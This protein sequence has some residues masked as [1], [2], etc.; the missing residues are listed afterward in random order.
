MITQ[1]PTTCTKRAGD[2]AES[3]GGEIRP[4]YIGPAPIIGALAAKGEMTYPA[5]CQACGTTYA[6]VVSV[7]MTLGDLEMVRDRLS[8]STRQELQQTATE[9]TDGSYQVEMADDRARDLASK[10]ATL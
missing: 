5:A 4:S 9:L 6:D 8:Q 10:A 7:P 1:T 2:R 3:C